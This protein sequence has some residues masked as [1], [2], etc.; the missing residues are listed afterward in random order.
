MNRETIERN[1]FIERYALGQL[2]Q[3][4]TTR[5]EVFLLENPDTIDEVETVER[6]IQGLTTLRETEAIQID[7]RQNKLHSIKQ[8]IARYLNFPVPAWGMAALFISFIVPATMFYN[9]ANRIAPPSG[10][11]ALMTIDST[12]AERG[13]LLEQ[14]FATPGH[15]ERIILAVLLQKNTHK[16]YQFN[17]LDADSNNKLWQ[18]KALYADFSDTLHVDMGVG[19]LTSGRY[20]YSITATEDNGATTEVEN[21]LFRVEG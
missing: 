20:A 4:D 16:T 5:F 11:V 13:T 12:W 19:Y 1:Q 3:A 15:E 8:L 9:P 2:S 7:R 10:M 17:L 14:V 6:M 18:S 21:G